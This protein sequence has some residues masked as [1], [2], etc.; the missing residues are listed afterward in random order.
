MAN[1]TYKIIDKTTWGPGPWQSEPD[2]VEFVLGGLQCLAL[3]MRSSGNWCGYVAVP[4]SHPWH[5]RGYSEVVPHHPGA[6]DREDADVSPIAILAAAGMGTTDEENGRAQIDLL[7][8]V[9]GGLTFSGERDG[10]PGLHFFGFDCGHA[11]DLSPAIHGRYPDRLRVS[12]DVYRE[13][14]YVLRQIERLADQ[15]L[16][17]AGGPRV[18]PAIEN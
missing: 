11:G 17:Y 2:R 1:D 16:S 15:L 9:H 14:P 3:R 13:L 6:M 7:I 12:S 18:Q 8:D 10:F 4:E 5:G